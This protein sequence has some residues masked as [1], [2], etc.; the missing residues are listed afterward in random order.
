VLQPTIRPEQLSAAPDQLPPCRPRD[1]LPCW[2]RCWRSLP[3]AT[4]ALPWEVSCAVNGIGTRGTH[5]RLLT[6][7]GV[8]SKAAAPRSRLDGCAHPSRP[9]LYLQTS[10]LTP[11]STLTS[12]HSQWARPLPTP[13]LQQVRC[14][15][16]RHCLKAVAPHCPTDRTCLPAFLPHTCSRPPGVRGC[17]RGD[18]VCAERAQR[19]V[20]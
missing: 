5:Q 2:P 13:C 14:T 1:S 17:G 7:D 10:C 16:G 4:P 12:T 11:Q 19:H 9:I 3:S 6:A 18:C 8:V 15:C 20:S